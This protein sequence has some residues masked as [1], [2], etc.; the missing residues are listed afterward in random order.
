MFL[1][2]I[3]NDINLIFLGSDSQ[4]IFFSLSTY[5]FQ[6]GNK[7]NLTVYALK[8]NIFRQITSQ[9]RSNQSLFDTRERKKTAG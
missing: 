1:F 5:F 9:I 2:L 6:A 8:K 7:V 3:T 4:I